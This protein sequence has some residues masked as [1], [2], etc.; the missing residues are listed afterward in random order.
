MIKRIKTDENGR[1]K[2]KC[3]LCKAQITVSAFQAMAAS[4]KRSALRTHNTRCE[5]A[6]DEERAYF[7]E[8]RVW[9]PKD[10]VSAEEALKALDD[11]H[12]AAKRSGADKLTDRQ[13]LKIIRNYR[14]EKVRKSD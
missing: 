7:R 12:K 13:I 3:G 2:V 8:H 1:A 9:P 14:E 10:W 4:N 11:C 5:F 6:S